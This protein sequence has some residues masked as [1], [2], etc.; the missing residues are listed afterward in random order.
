MVCT[1]L[2]VRTDSS[3]TSTVWKDVVDEGAGGDAGRG[4]RAVSKDAD[5]ASSVFDA[6]CIGI[7][8]HRGPVLS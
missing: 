4:P 3:G 5:A 1:Q 7:E 6:V 2:G 8:F